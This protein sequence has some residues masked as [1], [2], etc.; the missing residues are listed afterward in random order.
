MAVGHLLQAD[1]PA[2]Q[3]R[4]G[5][6]RWTAPKANDPANVEALDFLYQIYQEGIT[7]A[8]ELGGG[9]TLQGFF[10]TGKLA[11]TPAGGF[12]AGGLN[13]AGYG[14]WLLRC[15]VLAQVEESAPPVRH[16]RPVDLC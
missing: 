4:G 5:G 1:D 15:A 16:G 3:G 11:M 9:D 13:N 8:I 2:A 6:W 12:W 14:E 10:T 7:P